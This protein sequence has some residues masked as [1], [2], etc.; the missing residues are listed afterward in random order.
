MESSRSLSASIAV[1]MPEPSI[2]P[3]GVS[4]MALTG[5]AIVLAGCQNRGEHIIARANREDTCGAKPL[6]PFVGRKADQATREA[7]ERSKPNARPLRWIVPGEDILA[8]LS[9]GRINVTLDDNGTI[10]GIGCY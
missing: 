6:R 3:F 1:T 7:I 4:L 5:A 8:D 9:T 10:T 2:H